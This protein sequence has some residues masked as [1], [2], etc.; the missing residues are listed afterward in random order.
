MG[1]DKIKDIGSQSQ[2][3][4]SVRAL[5]TAMIFIKA[6]AFFRGD[7]EVSL[8]DVRQILPF[9]LHDKFIPDHDSPFFEAAGNAVYRV[10]R[11]GWIR[12]LFD[13]SCREYDRLN[14]DEDD[15]VRD[16]AEEFAPLPI[17]TANDGTL[18]TL[19]ELATIED[20]FDEDADRF[21][22]WNGHP[23]VMIDIYRIGDQTPIEVSKAGRQVIDALNA[24][25]PPGLRLAIR[26][27]RSEI[28]RQRIELLRK[29]GIIGI[30]LIQKRGPH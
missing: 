10:D 11:I 18:V 19:G 9:V 15:A 14:L 20:G 4:L 25:L 16:F 26:R 23:A 2:N 13:L 12:K 3:G 8:E 5:M 21:A 7:Q 29:N 28:Y 24:E 27:D 22:S 30:V 6:M 1:K 17:I